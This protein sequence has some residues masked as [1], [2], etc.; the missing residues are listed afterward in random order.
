MLLFSTRLLVLSIKRNFSRLIAVLLYSEKENIRSYREV[1]N[2]YVN[3]KVYFTYDF[4]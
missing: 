1:P 3:S 2:W 4:E